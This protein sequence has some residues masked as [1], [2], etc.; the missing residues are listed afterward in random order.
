M[1]QPRWIQVVF[2]WVDLSKAWSGLSRPMPDCLQPPNGVVM[3]LPSSG[4]K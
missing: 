2:T 3:S 1:P 4:G